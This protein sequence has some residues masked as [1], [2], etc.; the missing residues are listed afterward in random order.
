MSGHPGNFTAGILASAVYLAASLSVS[1]IA[2]DVSPPDFASDPSVGWFAYSRVFIP[3]ASGAGPVRPDPA[4]PLISNDE[5][6]AT[7]K[8]PTYPMGDPNSPILKPWAADAIRKY[9][10]RVLSGE[11]FFS[12]HATCRPIGVPHFLLLPM[13]RPMYFVQG[14]RKWR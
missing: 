10:A 13:T 7:G 14:R 1:A 6:R 4:H 9:N 5:F 11:N 12:L 8:Q 3:P 2:A